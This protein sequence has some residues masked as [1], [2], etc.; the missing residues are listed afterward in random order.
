MATK[1]VAVGNKRKATSGS[2][3]K[4]DS[5][6]ARLEES[7][8]QTT[9]ESSDDISDSD[10]EDGGAQLDADEPQKNGTSINDKT[11]DRSK[12]RACI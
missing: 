1:P 5:K 11:L 12:F 3:G 10:S 6:K 9:S 4:S 8:A 7:K 2:K